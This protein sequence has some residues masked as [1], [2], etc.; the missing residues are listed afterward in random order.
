MKA[1]IKFQRAN[2]ILSMGPSERVQRLNGPVLQST[3][4]V[5]SLSQTRVNTHQIGETG[6]SSMLTNKYGQPLVTKSGQYMP[7]SQHGASQQFA[8]NQQDVIKLLNQQDNRLNSRDR[9]NTENFY[10]NISSSDAYSCKGM[11]EIASIYQTEEERE[12]NRPRRQAVPNP[13]LEE[14][15]DRYRLKIERRF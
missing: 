2:Q 7:A 6:S 5:E 14:D 3:K 11:P 13:A 12:M 1:R 15:M 4:K 9:N 8:F 10:D